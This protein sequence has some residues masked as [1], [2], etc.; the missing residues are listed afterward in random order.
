MGLL[1]RDSKVQVLYKVNLQQKILIKNYNDPLSGYYGLARTME[2]LLHKY[3]WLRLKQEI[4]E[5]ISYC[6]KCQ[7]YKIHRYKPWGL[8]KSV[9]PASK[10]Q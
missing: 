5:Y 1:Y 10:L 9:P 3:Y 2:L 8:L 6:K 7:V 4:K